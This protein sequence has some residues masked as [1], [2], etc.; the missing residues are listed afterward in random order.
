MVQNYETPKE[1]EFGR[2]FEASLKSFV[3]YL[4]ACRPVAVSVHNA[5]KYIRWQI[6]QLP[7]NGSDKEVIAYTKL[8][9]LSSITIPTHSIVCS[10]AK[11]AS[12]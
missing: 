8:Y 4:Q 3:D 2:S 9:D 6:T 7:K 10:S 5:V 11:T 1:K 12:S